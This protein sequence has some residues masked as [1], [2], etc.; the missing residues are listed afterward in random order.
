MLN[1]ANRKLYR[2]LRGEYKKYARRL[3][4]T[5]FD[6]CRGKD[7]V[8]DSLSDVFIMLAEAQSARRAFADVIPDP[9]AGIRETALCFPARKM[10]RNTAVILC[11]CAALVLLGGSAVAIELSGD[12]WLSQPVPYYDAEQNTVYWQPVEHA[13]A[14]TISVNGSEV[15]TTGETIFRLENAP[16]EFIVIQVTAT[17]GGRYRESSGFVDHRPTAPETHSVDRSFSLWQLFLNGATATFSYP[18]GLCES[19]RIEI[20]PEV[21]AYVKIEGTVLG[22]YEGSLETSTEKLGQPLETNKYVLLRAETNYLLLL[23]P[24]PDHSDAEGIVQLADPLAIA[25]EGVPLPDGQTLFATADPDPE[26]NV[27]MTADGFRFAY[28]ESVIKL[29]SPSELQWMESFYPQHLGGDHG[30][31]FWLVDNLT[32]ERP[33]VLTDRL[34]EIDVSTERKSIE[35]P[36]GWSTYRFSIAKEQFGSDFKNWKYLMLYTNTNDALE[37]RRPTAEKVEFHVSHGSLAACDFIF[38]PRVF[39]T[40]PITFTISVFNPSESAA[41]IAYE[42]MPEISLTQEALSQGTLTLQ[43]GITYVENET[44]LLIMARAEREFSAREYAFL[45]LDSYN[46]TAAQYFPFEQYAYF[47]NPY[48]EPIVLTLTAYVPGTG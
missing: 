22:L 35:V 31:H 7:A 48:D 44:D 38:Y 1:K 10:R 26:E 28:M 23:D 16:E 45:R 39:E 12:V 33:L 41:R 30:D 3:K 36:A 18:A 42:I 46:L 15:G 14:Y 24:Q 34:Q 8:N 4:D 2:S 20:V 32:Q 13:Q 11:L 47:F 43:P 21:N 29:G 19:I 6:C 27:S 25:E 5:L 9:H 17:A 40:D 37:L